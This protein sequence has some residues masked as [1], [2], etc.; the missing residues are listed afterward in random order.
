MSATGSWKPG[1]TLISR[2]PNA[3]AT[4]KISRTHLVRFLA[5]LT[6]R[7]PVEEELQLDVLDA[8]AVQDASHL[9]QADLGGRVHRVG[10]MEADASVAGAGGRL[11]RSR[12]GNG[13]ISVGP[14][15]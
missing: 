14:S 6:I 10:V 15:G 7:E 9:G 5:T 1:P 8:V 4:A 2:R 13:L 11:D 3:S 12:N